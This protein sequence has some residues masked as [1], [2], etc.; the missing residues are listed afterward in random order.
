MR[1]RKMKQRDLRQVL[2]LL[3]ATPELSAIEGHHYI[4][5]KELEALLRLKGGLALVAEENGEVLGF[6]FGLL[7]PLDKKTGWL[8]NIAVK[9]K[10]R[11]RGVGGGLLREYEN[12]MKAR[13]AK[14][15]LLYLH[16]SMRLRK[17][18]REKGFRVGNVPL[19][20]AMKKIR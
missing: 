8:Y 5:G 16:G 11:G 6:A 17:F 10:A 4:G 12:S 13:G 15:L 7:E 2:A 18:Y 19:F 20:G 9:R 1:I 3:R 14:T